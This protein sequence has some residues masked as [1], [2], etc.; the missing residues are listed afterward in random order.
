MNTKILINKQA[1]S[2]PQP[3]PTL[4]RSQAQRLVFFANRQEV[5]LADAVLRVFRGGGEDGSTL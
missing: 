1:V 2:S 4:D 3:V 5:R